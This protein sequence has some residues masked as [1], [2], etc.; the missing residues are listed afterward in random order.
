M[1]IHDVKEIYDNTS[2]ASKYAFYIFHIFIRC[3]C[4]FF[5]WVRYNHSRSVVVALEMLKHTK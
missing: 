1:N 5:F 2:L 3:E 4:G